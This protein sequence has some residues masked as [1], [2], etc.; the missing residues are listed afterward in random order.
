MKLFIA[1]AVIF[2]YCLVPLGVSAQTE[3]ILQKLD[4]L[5]KFDTTARV[6]V[7]NVMSIMGSFPLTYTYKTPHGRLIGITLTY[8]YNESND[9]EI[10]MYTP[11]EQYSLE[12]NLAHAVWS[13]VDIEEVKALYFSK[14]SYSLIP[15][16]SD[17]RIQMNI[18]YHRAKKLASTNRD[19]VMILKKE[20][21]YLRDWGAPPKKK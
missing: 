9:I 11:P 3:N 14:L 8:P 4:S 1:V 5:Q 19:S 21:E 10:T 20:Y 18:L 15:K 2:M 7:G 6:T 16:V 13:Y 12:S 17:R